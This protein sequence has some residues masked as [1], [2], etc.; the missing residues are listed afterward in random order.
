MLSKLLRREPLPSRYLQTQ[1]AGNPGN[2]AS[3]D[4]HCPA[5]FY[6]SLHGWFWHRQVYSGLGAGIVMES[7]TLIDANAAS[8]PPE[9]LP[10]R[11]QERTRVLLTFQVRGK[12]R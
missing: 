11:D 12:G 1:F 5:L 9:V 2:I 4:D 6:P 10:R 8:S 3:Y 7:I